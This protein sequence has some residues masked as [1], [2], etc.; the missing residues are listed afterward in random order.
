[1]LIVDIVLVGLGPKQGP[2]WTFARVE[3]HKQHGRGE[4]GSNPHVR[5]G[6]PSDPPREDDAEPARPAAQGSPSGL[7]RLSSYE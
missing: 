1:M 2:P 4:W 7:K 6:A 5:V 3:G